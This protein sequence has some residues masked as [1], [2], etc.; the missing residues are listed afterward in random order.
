MKN[1]LKISTILVLAVA[2]CGALTLSARAT[3]S[4]KLTSGATITTITDNGTGDS[5]AATGVITYIGAVGGWNITVTTG[6]TQPAIGSLSLPEMDLNSIC[7]TTGAAD[8]LTIAFSSTDYTLGNNNVSM[9]FSETSTTANLTNTAYYDPSN[10]I[11]AETDEIGSIGSLGP[12]S[13]HGNTTGWFLTTSPFSLTEVVTLDTTGTTTSSF[14]AHL[15][16]VPL[17]A[18]A[19]LLGTGLLGLVGLGRRRRQRNS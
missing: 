1:L 6:A 7:T 16:D 14:D 9:S 4:L 11:F 13:D 5:N 3:T 8:Q 2:L 12:P 17:P 19:L 10:N 18:T 15:N